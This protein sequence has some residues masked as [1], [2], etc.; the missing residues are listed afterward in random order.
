MENVNMY[1]KF[2]D[3]AIIGSYFSRLLI[4]NVYFAYEIT[5]TFIESCE[6]TIHIFKEKF[7]INH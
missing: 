2:K 6:E 7:P 4:N 5:I 3:T 1:M